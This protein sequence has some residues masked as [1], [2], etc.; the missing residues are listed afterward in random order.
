MALCDWSSDVCSSDL[1]ARKSN[2]SEIELEEAILNIRKRYN[3]EFLKILPPDKVD[4]FWKAEKQFAN[5]VKKEIE[6][7][8]L[9]QQQKRSFDNP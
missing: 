7:R 6:R 2:K 9:H 4:I 5:F 3:T 8:Q 1:D